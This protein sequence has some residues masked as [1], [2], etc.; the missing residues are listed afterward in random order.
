MLVLG[1]NGWGN[2]THDASACLLVDGRVAAFA[3]EERFTR[4]KHSFDAL[5]VN[6]ARYCLDHVGL[7]LP[8]IDAVAFGWNI[9]R[10][11]ED[12]GIGPDRI[13]PDSRAILPRE[14]FPRDREPRFEFIDHH[15]AHAASAYHY[16]E[17]PSAAVMVLDG[18]GEDASASLYHGRDGKLTRLRS[19]PIGWSLGYFYEA[20]CAYAGM[21]TFDAGKLMGL[22]AH[23]RA[24]DALD[25]LVRITGDGYECPAMAA[26][27]VRRGHS[28]EQEPVLVDWTKHFA[29]RFALPPNRK[30]WVTAA[31]G[32]RRS[33]PAR[34]V[35][36]YRD[37][38]ATVQHLLEEAVLAMA[39][40][41][42]RR[43]GERVLAVAGG[44]GFNATLNGRLRRLPDSTRCSCSR[45]AGPPAS[46]SALAALSRPYP[47]TTWCCSLG[48]PRS[49]RI[50]PDDIRRA[51]EDTVCATPSRTTSAHAAA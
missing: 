5:P 26:D 44:V 27:Y 40:D 6:A 38:A 30:E 34:D 13:D 25:D 48:S 36:A 8:D 46:P 10:L 4:R 43:T 15:L 18:Q 22:A 29:E 12:R 45:I 2:R 23:G 24:S 17:S 39:R 41:L 49:V 31:D 51:L 35:Y 9:P 3:E 42:L 19:Y 1:L 20:A 21:R 37:V 14:H 50:G 32:T 16:A 33:V 11:V 7:E 47:A 28:D